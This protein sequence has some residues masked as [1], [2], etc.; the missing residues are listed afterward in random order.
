MIGTYGTRSSRR[1]LIIL[2]RKIRYVDIT[3]RKPL[4]LF[5]IISYFTL[6]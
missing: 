1:Y 6:F 2:I 4:V 5:K 3:A